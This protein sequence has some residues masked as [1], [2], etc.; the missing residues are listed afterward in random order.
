MAQYET[1][2]RT[3]ITAIKQMSDIHTTIEWK[4]WL[5]AHSQEELMMG[6]S[7]MLTDAVKTML[8]GDEPPTISGIQSLPPVSDNHQPGVYFGL[9]QPILGEEADENTFGYVSSA[10]RVG[11]GFQGRVPDHLSATY[12]TKYLE[13]NPNYYHYLLLADGSRDESFYVLAQTE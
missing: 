8:G 7:S 5:D 9:I 12:R 11:R 10:T 3:I 6:V 13:K 1:R 2:L 4:K